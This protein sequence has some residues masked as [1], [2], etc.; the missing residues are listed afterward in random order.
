MRFGTRRRRGLVLAVLLLATA[1][2]YAVL[3]LSLGR[4]A[5]TSERSF[6]SPAPD[7]ARRLGI[8]VEALS[9]DP[10]NESVRLRISLTPDTDTPVRRP[11][12]AGQDVRLQVGDGGSRQDL[13]FRGQQPAG[14]AIVEA[15]LHDGAVTDY[16]FDRF[17]AMLRVAAYD[18]ASPDDAARPIALNVVVWE[19]IA[20]WVMEASQEASDGAGGTRLQLHIRRGSALA[21]LALA[22]YGGMALVACAA[23]TIG[24]SVFLGIRAAESTLTGALGAMLFALPALRAALP[25][26]PPLG[27]CADLLVFLWAELA[28][29]LGLAL[30][31]VTWV[32][33]A[34]ASPRPEPPRRPVQPSPMENK[35]G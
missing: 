26:A 21:F 8:Y 20:G 15:D 19:R 1:A 31:I 16:P 11:D 23:L 30:F 4:D 12:A 33:G 32:R 24:S 22:V 28:V 10:V 6:A 9:I 25:G 29:A 14:V 13:V 5:A 3:A 7:G 18:G 34:P 2:S 35:H 17:R 27:V